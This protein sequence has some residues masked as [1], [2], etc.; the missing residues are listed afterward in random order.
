MNLLSMSNYVLESV[1]VAVVVVDKCI[2]LLFSRLR[3]ASTS[4]NST[5]RYCVVPC[6]E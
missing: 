4:E 2:I 3:Y 1:F 6:G 5:V